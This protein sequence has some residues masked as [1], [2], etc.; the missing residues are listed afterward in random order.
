MKIDEEEVA[1][2]VQGDNRID[3]EAM[4]RSAAA[5][6]KSSTSEEPYYAKE[7]RATLA[8]ELDQAICFLERAR[9]SLREDRRTLFGTTQALVDAVQR[10][11]CVLS[12]QVALERELKIGPN[13]FLVNVRPTEQR[14]TPASP[15]KWGTEIPE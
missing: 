7:L 10:V 8:W 5:W 13:P 1:S 3:W 2:D 11:L 14:K 12:N 4:Y 6:Q 9:D 15:S